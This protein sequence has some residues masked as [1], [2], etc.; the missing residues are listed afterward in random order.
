VDKSPSTLGVVET[1]LNIEGRILES[2]L[3][4]GTI[5]NM[6][7]CIH[8]SVPVRGRWGAAV[9]VAQPP[10]RSAVNAMQPRARKH[11]NRPVC[12]SFSSPL[13]FECACGLPGTLRLPPARYPR[14]PYSVS[15]RV[16]RS[17]IFQK[18]VIA[19]SYADALS[20]IS[21]TSLRS[22][23]RP[24]PRRPR[25]VTSRVSSHLATT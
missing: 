13:P 4:F 8:A 24:T 15:Y 17:I 10:T 11:A 18:S 21:Q 1:R 14:S 16:L 23:A 3:E 2:R 22:T 7:C 9:G 12:R 25:H 6:R 20:Y 19:C 5:V